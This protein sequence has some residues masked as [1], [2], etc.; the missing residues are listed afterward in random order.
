VV[1]LLRLLR[2]RVAAGLEGDE[3]VSRRVDGVQHPLVPCLGVHGQHR[4]GPHG[5]ED[6]AVLGLIDA[7]LADDRDERRG[8]DIGERL[9]GIGAELAGVDHEGAR[10][11]RDPGPPRVL[12][13]PDVLL[14][15]ER[16]HDEDAVALR[17]GRRHHVGGGELVLALLIGQAGRV[18]LLR[19]DPLR[20]LS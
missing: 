10:R 19:E 6:V 8:L 3:P 11:V 9:G 13:V 7:G 4:L 12:L 5:H 15:R 16:A 18:E 2:V 1:V 17:A 20:D 14:L